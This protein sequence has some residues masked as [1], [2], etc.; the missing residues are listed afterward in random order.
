MKRHE[1][2][3]ILDVRRIRLVLGHILGYQEKHELVGSESIIEAKHSDIHSMEKSQGVRLG[4]SV[5]ARL[6][7][8]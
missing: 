5:A 4:R 3:T 8:G 7:I 1:L 6:K 2:R